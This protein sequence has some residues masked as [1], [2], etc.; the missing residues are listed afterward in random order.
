ME[1]RMPPAEANNP[2][3]S[4][5]GKEVVPAVA[6]PPSAPTNTVIPALFLIF[7]PVFLNPPYH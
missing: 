7:F 5:A 1:I 2:A 4:A 6:K 3:P